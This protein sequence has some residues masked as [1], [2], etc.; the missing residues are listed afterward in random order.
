MLANN[1]CLAGAVTYPGQKYYLL[2]RTTNFLEE[3]AAPKNWQPLF[4]KET[5]RIS[6]LRLGWIGNPAILSRVG[7]SS[8]PT[9]R[10]RKYEKRPFFACNF[11]YSSVY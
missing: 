2:T 4:T 5:R 11:Q 6:T 10:C 8:R 3:D 1:T 7:L 9:H